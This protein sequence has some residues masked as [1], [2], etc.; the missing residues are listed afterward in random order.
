MTDKEK[1]IKFVNDLIAENEV[2]YQ[3][4]ADE[5]GT[6]QTDYDRPEQRTAELK[7]EF[8][9]LLDRLIEKLDEYPEIRKMVYVQDEK[10]Q[11]MGNLI[12]AYESLGKDSIPLEVFKSALYTKST[13]E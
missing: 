5:F 1:L 9:P 11:R 3:G 13:F 8:K 4:V 2:N 6:S 12:R 7:D 10:L